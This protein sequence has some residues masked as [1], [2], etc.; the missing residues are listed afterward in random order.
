MPLLNF[1][2]Q[3]ASA[4]KNRT[5]RQTIRAKRKHPIKVDD[6]LYLYTGLRTKHTKKLGKAICL[7]TEDIVITEEST[8]IKNLGNSRWKECGVM[9]EHDLAWSDGFKGVA[10]MREYFRSTHGLPF[11]GDLIK[12]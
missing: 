10:E 5:K 3:F 12:W 4:V 6:T 1:Q 11:S 2:K 8:F 7:S 9:E